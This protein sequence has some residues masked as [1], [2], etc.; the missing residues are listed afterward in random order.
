MSMGRTRKSNPDGLPRRLYFRHGQY[1]YAHKKGIAH[2]RGEW[3]PLGADLA[4]AR[5][6]ADRYN[7][8]KGTFGTIAHWLDEFIAE[9]EKRRGLPRSA[10]G[11]MPR[12]VEDYR[13]NC[14]PLKTF[15]GKMSPDGVEPQH[16]MQYLSIG[17]QASRMVR[18]NRE[19]AT[20]RA[21]FSWMIANAKC[22]TKVNPCYRQSG[23]RRNPEEKRDRYIEDAEFAAVMAVATSPQVRA[24]AG[25]IYRTLQRPSDILRWTAAN[26]ATRDG[27][28][29][30]SFRQ[31]KTGKQMAIRI[32]PEID[33]LVKLA[34]DGRQIRGMTLIHR[35][36]GQPYAEKSLAGMWGEYRRK[37]GVP[38][39][40]IYDLKGKGATDM[41]TSGVPLE[42][43]QDLC[44]HAS[45]TTTE[46]YIKSRLRGVVE[47]NVVKARA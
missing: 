39:F 28:R 38:D 14:I 12:T 46:I 11:L 13:T 30:L 5:S 18:A 31:G 3:E 6:I 20:L 8:A 4:R 44:G 47:P 9:C 7:D 22:D 43:I 37:A 32:T 29:V 41:Y 42:L 35:N 33:D 21:A 25:L 34:V 40:A 19:V 1:F 23:V 2:P 24:L 45:I 36:N 16:V 15:F 17:A 26:I 27:A 10:R